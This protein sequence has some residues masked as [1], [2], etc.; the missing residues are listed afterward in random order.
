MGQDAAGPGAARRRRP[1]DH[2]EVSG[3]P[4]AA[5]GLKTCKARIRWTSAPCLGLLPWLGESVR[6]A[7]RS[8]F[9]GVPPSVLGTMMLQ[10]SSGSR[11]RAVRQHA[12]LPLCP[13]LATIALCLAFLGLGARALVPDLV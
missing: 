13:V 1:Q 11:R 6:Q 5:D 2:R 7:S 4:R 10:A 12:T 3:S 9:L 8:R